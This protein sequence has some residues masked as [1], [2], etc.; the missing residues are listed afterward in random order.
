VS[1]LVQDFSPL[2]RSR[3]DPYF[4]GTSLDFYLPVVFRNTLD[5][6]LILNAMEVYN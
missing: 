5:F 1:S 3:D 2:N 4:G 6:A